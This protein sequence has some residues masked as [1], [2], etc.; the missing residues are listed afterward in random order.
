M[1]QSGE[2][3]RLGAYSYSATSF[4]ET[5]FGSFTS[6]SVAMMGLPL[7]RVLLSS[8][9]V[10]I[11]STIIHT[12]LKWHE[13]DYAAL[14]PEQE[15]AF[16]A[17]PSGSFYSPHRKNSP[18][19]Q[20]WQ[21]R[22]KREPAVMIRVRSSKHAEHPTMGIHLSLWF[23]YVLVVSAVTAYA[24][25]LAK[26]AHST[27]LCFLV[28]FL[29]YWGAEPSKCIWYMVPVSQAAKNAVDSLLY[30]LAT[31]LALSTYLN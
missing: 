27:S 4:Y 11:V 1:R 28:S 29:A 24:E 30:A 25:T 14:T 23:L 7:F 10:F 20:A 18:S 17:F 9:L 22:C 12:V 13:S 16:A 31:T 5:F 15:R 6:I 8:V 19:H 21:E 3:F 2:P 26:P